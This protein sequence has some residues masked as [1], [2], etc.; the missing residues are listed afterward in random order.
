MNLV[1]LLKVFVLS[2][3]VV[4]NIECQTISITKNDHL[5]GGDL[6]KAIGIYR[7][8]GLKTCKKSFSL[9]VCEYSKMVINAVKNKSKMENDVGAPWW[10]W[11]AK[12]YCSGGQDPCC[13]GMW[14]TRREACNSHRA[15]C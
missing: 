8:N 10:C 7:Q 14:R 1:L 15:V 13:I 4:V 6:L 3:F 11:A 12:T 5:S 2:F 9:E